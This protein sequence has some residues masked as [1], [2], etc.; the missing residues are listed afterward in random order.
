MPATFLI[1]GLVAAAG[2][3][4]PSLDKQDWERFLKSATPSVQA[5]EE[6][7]GHPLE[8]DTAG[9]EGR[10]YLITHRAPYGG[11]V[12][13]YAAPS[14]DVQEVI[15]YLKEGPLYLDSQIRRAATFKTPWTLADVERWYGAPAERSTSKR[16]ATTTL[17]YHL[18]G[19]KVRSLLFTSCPHSNYL[20]RIVAER[21]GD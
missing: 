18:D 6:W 17:T 3:L 14:G 8:L 10:H 11:G 4:S 13:V 1:A 16:N 7:A 5:V 9:P 15:F 2:Q 12:D 21:A 20:Y 19:D